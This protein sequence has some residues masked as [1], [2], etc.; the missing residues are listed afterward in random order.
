MAFGFQSSASPVIDGDNDYVELRRERCAVVDESCAC[1]HSTAMNPARGGV[2][3]RNERRLG[4]PEHYWQR[5]SRIIVCPFRAPDVEEKA[6]S[7]V[8]VFAN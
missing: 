7:E 3:H 6:S 2:K 4:S 1:D 8:K 5:S